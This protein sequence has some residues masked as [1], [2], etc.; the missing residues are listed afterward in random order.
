MINLEH[1]SS[2]RQCCI[3]FF[4]FNSSVPM[5]RMWG[6][7]WKQLSIYAKSMTFMG[8]L[9]QLLSCLIVT[10]D[11][12]LRLKLLLETGIYNFCLFATCSWAPN[13]VVSW[14]PVL[15]IYLFF[16]IF[17]VSTAYFTWWLKMM[18]YQQR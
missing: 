1:S 5:H 7:G 18:K 11:F 16:S 8:C 14:P 9:V 2:L 15:I 4:F 3:Y 10:K 13:L 12:S 17:V 6:E